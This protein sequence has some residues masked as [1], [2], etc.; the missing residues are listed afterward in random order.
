MEYFPAEILLPIFAGIN[1][2]GLLHLASTSHRFEAIAQVVFKERYATRYFMIDGESKRDQDL[3]S[4]QF[5]YFG[6]SIKAINVKFIQDIDKNHWMAQIL[7]NH[8]KNLEK[9]SFRECLFKNA[10][11]FLL[12]HREIT[13]LTF[14]FARNHLTEKFLLPKY[15]NLKKLELHNFSR[16][17]EHSLRK[18]FLNNPQLESLIL[19]FCNHYFTLPKIMEIVH[20]HLKLLKEFRVLDNFDFQADFPSSKCVDKFVNA[21]KCV[22][23][24][25][26]TIDVEV[27]TL[28]RRLSANCKNIKRLELYVIG[29]YLYDE[30]IE[31]VRLF[32]KVETLSLLSLLSLQRV[33]AIVDSLPNLRHLTVSILDL[34]EMRYI[35]SLLQKCENL[36]KLVIELN[37]AL[38]ELD[39][40]DESLRNINSGFHDEFVKSIHKR[41]LQLEFTENGE[42][43]GYVTEAEI[44][45]KNKLVHWVGYD[46]IYNQTN[47]NL[48]DLAKPQKVLNI[49][50]SGPFNQI[51]DYLDLS[52]LNSLNRTGERAKQLVESYMQEHSTQ[53]KK[54]YIT[55]EFQVNFDE[56]PAFGRYVNNLE[57]SLLNGSGNQL[58]YVMEEYFKNVRK[59]CLRTRTRIDPH[60]FIFPQVRHFIFYGNGSSKNCTYYC[61][62]TE[63]SDICPHL[64]S[65]EFET[66]VKLFASDEHEPQSFRRLKL[67]KFKPFDE[68]QVQYAKELFEHRDTQLIIDN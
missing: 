64:E 4:A 19:R 59:L 20:K 60:N 5:R 43:I 53:Q 28:M 26:M 24:L 65:M 48:L 57:I 46:P 6:G 44:I 38:I 32:D 23:S 30:I 68:S 35:F 15:R 51:L 14:H 2:I 37:T 33:E 12:Q 21:M 63:L 11:E 54:F 8:T 58:R 47:L 27:T 34:Q 7:R 50:K 41:H 45:W 13:H 16:V 10:F 55:D 62:L 67:F 9:L 25:G 29:R 36:E 18:I 40:E 22:D 61:N 3:Y 1:D 49:E 39:D 42:T 52:S 66:V 17:Y 56:L 31:V